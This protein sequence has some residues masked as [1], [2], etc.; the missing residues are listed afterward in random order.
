MLGVID[1]R[2]L[3][4]FVLYLL[5]R[6]SHV[7]LQS[8]HKSRRADNNILVYHPLCY[9]DPSFIHLPS[10]LFF[11]NFSNFWLPF[12]IHTHIEVLW[13]NLTRCLNIHELHR[14]EMMC[15]FWQV[16]YILHMVLL[17]LILKNCIGSPPNASVLCCYIIGEFLTL[18]TLSMQMIW[19]FGVRVFCYIVHEFLPLGTLPMQ[20]LSRFMVGFVAIV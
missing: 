14:H 6:Q 15:K 20:M 16:S 1:I 2:S 18:E 9:P 5:P 8:K 10:S 17:Y 11:F 19:E 3:P 4:R 7:T 13:C 12:S